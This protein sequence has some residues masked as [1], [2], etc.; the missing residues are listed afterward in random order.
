MLCLSRKE[1][2]VIC[3]GDHIRI[4]VLEVGSERVRLGVEAPASV[5]VDREELRARKLREKDDG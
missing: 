3:I 2:Q 5:S 4:T 1:K